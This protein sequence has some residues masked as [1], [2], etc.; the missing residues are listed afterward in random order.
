M[1]G[2][3]APADRT[4]VTRLC[5]PATGQLT[6]QP[7]PSRQQLHEMNSGSLKRSKRTAGSFWKV[8]ATELQNAGPWSASTISCCPVACAVPAAL[9]CRS[10]IA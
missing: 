4:A 1:I 8:E 3:V 7:V 9:Q 10:R 2:W 5:I 6:G